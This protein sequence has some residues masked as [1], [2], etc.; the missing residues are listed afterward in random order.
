MAEEGQDKFTVYLDGQDGHRGNVLLH[1]FTTKLN[2]LAIVL[3]KLERAY[4]GAG[5]RQTDFEIIEV[6]KVN[7]TSVTLRAVPH[8]L[9]YN[10][11]PAFQ[12][13]MVQIRT[14]G[15]GVPPDER[16]T[17]DIADDLAKLATRDSA[18]GYKAFWINGYAEKVLF[19]EQYQEHAARLAALR[20]REVTSDRWH[21]GTSLGSI[22]GELKKLDDFEHDRE[23]V[24]VPPVG[25]PITCTFPDSMQAEMGLYWSQ[26][27]RVSGLLHYSAKSP[28]PTRVD[29]Q[30]GGIELYPAIKSRRTL[31]QMRGI[32]SD[33]ERTK[34]EWDSLLNG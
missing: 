6:A 34:V 17:A 7:P 33:R 21:E 23:F 4:L 19:D 13:S 9:D 32:F 14:V 31:A 30:E 3:G 24:I 2:R 20:K 10:P 26:V 16:V 5:T 25:T 12:W 22:V 27:V 8:V 18:G 11:R 29:V 28:F 15:E 1:S